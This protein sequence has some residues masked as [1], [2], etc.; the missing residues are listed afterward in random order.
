MG[1]GN[2]KSLAAFDLA[3]ALTKKEQNKMRKMEP[4]I[5]YYLARMPF[6]DGKSSPEWAKAEELREGMDTIREKAKKR[7]EELNGF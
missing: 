5:Q 2:K 6:R 7:W 4:M 3:T 1:K